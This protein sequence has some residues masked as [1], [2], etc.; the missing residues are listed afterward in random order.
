MN[1]IIVDSQIEV[2]KYG[3]YLN[4]EGK[5]PYAL[6]SRMS[7]ESAAALAMRWTAYLWR[8]LNSSRT[9]SANSWVLVKTCVL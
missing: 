6:L 1:Q 9:N 4:F 7:A 3:P 5:N 8:R 2:A